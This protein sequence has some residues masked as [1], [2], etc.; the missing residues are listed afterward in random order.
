[1]VS[2]RLNCTHII[3]VYWNHTELLT[4]RIDLITD[5]IWTRTGADCLNLLPNDH[6]DGCTETFQKFGMSFA[7]CQPDRSF[8]N[9]NEKNEETSHHVDATEATQENLKINCK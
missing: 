5:Q 4:S 6:L 2:F 8:A 1:M 9:E 3:L 7:S